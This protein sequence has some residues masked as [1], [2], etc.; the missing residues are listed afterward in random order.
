MAKQKMTQKQREDR[1]RAAEERERRAE[2][3]KKRKE[4]TKQIFTIVVC[5]ILVLALGVPTV[6]LA[7]LGGG[8]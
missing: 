7:L 4:R 2:E 1:I 3:A 8:A 6:G 5:V